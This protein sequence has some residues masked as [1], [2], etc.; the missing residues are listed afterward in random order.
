MRNGIKAYFDYVNAQGGVHGRK[1]E[2]RTL[3]DGYEPAPCPTPR[4]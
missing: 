2:L 4:S 3:D 1:I